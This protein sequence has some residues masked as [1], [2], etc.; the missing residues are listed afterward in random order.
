[1]PSVRSASVL[2]ST[3]PGARVLERVLSSLAEQELRI[4]WDVL[5]LDCGSADGTREILERWRPLF[6]VPLEVRRVD[7]NELDLGDE[8]NLLAAFSRGEVLVFLAGDSAPLSNRWL[9]TLLK[10]F[11][12]P[13]VGAVSCLGVPGLQASFV[14]RLLGAVGIRRA[15]ARRVVVVPDRRAYERLST[16]EK[17]PLLALHGPAFAIRRESWKRHPFPRTRYGGADLIARALLE[18]GRSIVHNPRAAVASAPDEAPGE[19]FERP[20]DEARFAPTRMLGRKDLSI[21]YVV[22]GFPPDTWAGTE[23]YTLNLAKEMQRR[24]HRVTILTRAPAERGVA[25]GGPPEFSLD[26]GDF[27]GLRVIRMVHR[28]EHQRL[29]QS[30]DQP[31]A[32]SIFRCVLENE[33]FDLVHFMHLIHLSVG[34]VDAARD[35]GLATLITCHD[36]W[37]ICA[38]VQLIRPDGVRCVQNMGSGCLL[39][40]KER[41]LSRI[42]ALSRLDATA[43]P[44]LD[45]L[46]AGSR[47]GRVLP[48]KLARLFEGYADIRARQTRVTGAYRTVDLRISPSRFLRKKLVDTAGFDPGTFLFSDNGMRTDHVLARAKSPDPE[49]R[50]RFGFVG[51]LVWYKGGE[52]MLKAMRRLSGLPAVL[53]IHGDFRPTSDPHHAALERLAGSNVVFHGRFDNDRLSEVY[54]SIDVLVVPSLWWENSPITIHEAFLARTPVLASGIGGMAEFVRD[55]VDGLHFSAGDDADLA[56]KMR[57]FLDEPDLIERLSRDFPRVKTIEEDAVVTEVRYRALCCLD[58]EAPGRGKP[59]LLFDRTGVET[60]A[61]EGSVEQQGPEMLLLRPPTGAVEFDLAEAGWGPRTILVEQF[62]LGSEPDVLLGGR[63]L[64][65]GV[66]IGM[67]TTFHAS[68][69]DETREARLPVE[70]ARG[71]R[72]LRLECGQVNMRL[73]RVTV[74]TRPQGREKP[75]ACA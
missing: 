19:A 66:E 47:H 21:L 18:S 72:R 6:P 53:N 25:A 64:V 11:D 65:D 46:A 41:N 58:R 42:P 36:Y 63:A 16:E 69:K 10:D 54:S 45:E 57:R 28:L 24:G 39:C 35:L 49:G 30:Y 56:A 40:V 62:A 37:A 8:A 22:H 7:P 50:V 43:G 70:M 67:F 15:H 75:G 60:C 26:E 17:R 55:G 33:D 3:R 61:R 12:N 20:Q 74:L 38:R 48:E 52:V 34:L 27:Q 31:L 32:E 1:M 68:G 9:R 29:A 73:K 71:A 51:S 14:E 44:L 4:P 2:L 59:R 13:K 23:V 5:A